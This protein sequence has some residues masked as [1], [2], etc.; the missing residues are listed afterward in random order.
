LAKHE[1]VRE[2]ILSDDEI[3]L[4]WKAAG[5]LGAFGSLVKFLLV[6]CARRSEASGMTHDE[7]TEAKVQWTH[8]KAEI[9]Q[10][11]WMLPGAR[12]KTN[13]PLIRPLSKLAVQILDEAPK[14][15]S[16]KLFFSADGVHPVSAFSRWKK[17]LDQRVLEELRKQDPKAQP[18]QPWTLHDLR[19]T[20]RSLLSKT[21]VRPDI[22][23]MCLGHL[24][25]NSIQQT[26]DVYDFAAEKLDAF[27]RLARLIQVITT[28]GANVVQFPAAAGGSD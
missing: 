23:E 10:V 15:E 17:Q 4:I 22:S 16:C 28:G 24:V 8:G 12:S 19:R 1:N 9:S 20:G 25:G 7:V 5:D 11:V 13:K 14:F 27:E 2:R 6:S 21:G 18:L 3:R 26:Y